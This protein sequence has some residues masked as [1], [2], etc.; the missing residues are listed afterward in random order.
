MTPVVVTLD[1]SFQQISPL[2]VHP[3]Y[4]PAPRESETINT[5]KKRK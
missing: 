2:P 4:K 5:K 3:R 1:N